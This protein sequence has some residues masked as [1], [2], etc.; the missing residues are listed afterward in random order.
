MDGRVYI[1]CNPGKAITPGCCL[2]KQVGGGNM[3]I[4]ATFYS[5]T[6]GFIIY[7]KGNLSNATDLHITEIT[8]SCQKSC[9]K[10]AALFSRLMH[11]A[12]L[13]E[14]YGNGFRDIKIHCVALNIK[15]PRF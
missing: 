2:G 11:R 8:S 5:E 9:K 7:V 14:M 13:N 10:A 12:T 6:L 4:C 3:I 15:L 1:R